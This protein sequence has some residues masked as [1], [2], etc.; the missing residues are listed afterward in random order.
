M[1][2]L[3]K[4][5]HFMLFYVKM[6]TCWKDVTYLMVPG[7]LKLSFHL[8]VL[9]FGVVPC[10]DFLV[11]IK[12]ISW[13][14]SANITKF[15]TIVLVVSFCSRAYLDDFR[16]D[17]AQGDQLHNGEDPPLEKMQLPLSDSATLSS[18]VN[19]IIF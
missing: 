18:M 13:R 6:I 5:I 16:E 10:L 12:W 9:W 4:F 3:R 14:L 11:Y 19:W 7:F 15:L 2:I 1:C 17:R 8:N